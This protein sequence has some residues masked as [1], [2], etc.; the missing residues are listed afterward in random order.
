MRTVAEL[1]QTIPGAAKAKRI[2]YL[3]IVLQ[4]FA[5]KVERQVAGSRVSY[6]AESNGIKHRGITGSVWRATRMHHLPSQGA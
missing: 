2:R 3:A 4:T 6:F 5:A 1:L